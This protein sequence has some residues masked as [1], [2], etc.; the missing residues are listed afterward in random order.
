M[1]DVS[2]P[3]QSVVARTAYL[4]SSDP[5][6]RVVVDVSEIAAPNDP[7]VLTG[8]LHG[9]ITLNADPSNPAIENPAIENPAIEN[10]D[11]LTAEVFTPVISS[12]V[13]SPAIENPAIENP[14]IENPAIENVGA[15]NLGII[16]PAIENPAIENPAIENPAIENPA[17]ENADLVNGSI[18]DT[19]WEL[20]NTGNTAAA[21]AV[22]LVLN[23]PIPD[24]FKTQLIIHK[25]YTTPAAD[26]CDLKVQLQNVIVANITSP[27]FVTAADVGNPAIENPAIENATV[28]LAPARPPMS[29]SGC[30]TRTRA[31][32]SRSTP[33]RA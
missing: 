28:A 7:A 25:T 12:A 30:S 32:R 20:T 4:S 14:A 27:A 18:S 13:T 31:I 11:I 15:A 6:A 24:G 5:E 1:L 10:P 9:T 26:G 3:P 29:P 16:N 8:G 33:R 21:Y 23:D 19:T 22:K 2:V 17:I